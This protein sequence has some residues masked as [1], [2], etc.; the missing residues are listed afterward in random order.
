M[1]DNLTIKEHYKLCNII[2]CPDHLGFKCYHQYHKY[3]VIPTSI[4]S[5]CDRKRNLGSFKLFIIL[6]R[7]V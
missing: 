7:R 4:N 3:D 6:K 5:L 1:F 2:N